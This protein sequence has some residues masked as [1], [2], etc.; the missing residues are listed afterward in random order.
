MTRPSPSLGP[1]RDEA[2]GAPVGDE[3]AR[4]TQADRYD[5][6]VSLVGL[7]N[8]LLRN[9]SVLVVITLIF[10]VGSV[11][12]RLTL[13]RTWT[14]AASF[15]PQ[16]SDATPAGLGSL[17]AQF[18]ITVPNT[19]PGESPA[20]YADLLESRAILDPVLQ[21]VFRIADGEEERRGTLAELYEIGGRSES[22][23]QEGALRRLRDDVSVSTT[24]TTDVVHLSVTAPWRALA[25]LIAARM[26]E[27]VN[28]FN[29]KTR[30]SQA[31]EE[32][33]FVESRMEEARSELSGAEDQLR[34]FLQ[35][36]REFRNSPEL[37]LA[38]DRLQRDVIWRQEVFTSLAQAYE[39]ARIEEVRSNPV[40]TIIEAPVRPF[41]PDP[42]GLVKWTVVALFSGLAIAVLLA[43]VL[44]FLRR[45]DA[46][47]G[48]EFREFE[49]LRTETL[50]DLRRPW[51]LLRLRRSEHG[52]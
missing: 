41:R 38:H 14:S 24:R 42:R 39:Q 33:R 20:F 22:L 15:M 17:A 16:R 37:L 32:R 45:R 50:K 48:E 35:R 7:V 30:Q 12:Y 6:E 23:R 4:I 9:R 52:V 40:I 11:T 26:L 27:L 25:G 5:D 8:V 34:R 13:P 49:R 1:E 44:D 3:R 47:Q 19:R 18:G 10:F 43:F 29:L 21:T 2:S 36:N 51:R 46:Q 28:E 31:G